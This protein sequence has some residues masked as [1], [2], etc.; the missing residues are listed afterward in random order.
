MT[1]QRRP[2]PVQR[3]CHAILDGELDPLSRFPCLALSLN[4]AP[5]F[6]CGCT[7]SPNETRYSSSTHISTRISLLFP[8]TQVSTTMPLTKSTTLRSSQATSRHHLQ[9]S[10]VL[11]RLDTL[12]TTIIN[13][14]C[15]P[16]PTTQAI[17]HSEPLFISCLL[18][19]L[20]FFFAVLCCLRGKQPP[21]LFPAPLPLGM[22]STPL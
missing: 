22:Q 11:S 18:L 6:R 19:D 1:F 15:R 3:L 13:T 12:A 8:A 21:F 10:F 5:R 20:T 16:R 2:L 9:R 17:R 14:L 7:D 4:L